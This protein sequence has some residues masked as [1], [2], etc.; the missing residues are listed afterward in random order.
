MIPKVKFTTASI[1]DILNVMMELI[2]SDGIISAERIFN[3]YPTLKERLSNLKSKDKKEAV[4]K[5]FKKQEEKNKKVFETVREDFEK[6]WNKINDDIMIAL[7]KVHEIKWSNKFNE[8]TARVNSN[9][10]C[11]R[12]LN[13]NTFDI[14]FAIHNDLMKRII[15]HEI[16]H[17]I[18]FEKWKQIFPEADAREFETPHLIW[19]FSE[20]VPYVILNDERIQEVFPHEPPVYDVWKKLEINNKPILKKLEEIYKKRKNFEDFIKNSWKF[21]QEN[22]D[23][24]ERT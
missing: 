14:Y 24:I 10:I 11:P 1:D 7:E 15:V 23:K 22:K 13:K 17:F 3:K 18:F 19:K 20:M 4:R 9:P 2:N 6:E 21:I 16:S 8:F 12:Y 5:F